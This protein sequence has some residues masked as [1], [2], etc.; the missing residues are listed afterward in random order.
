MEKYYV[1]RFLDESKEVVYVGKT[2]QPIEKRMRIHFSNSGHLGKRQIAKVKCVEFIELENRTEMDIAEL[3]YINKWKPLFNIQSKYDDDCLTYS[4]DDTWEVFD[5]DII[6]EK[7]KEIPSRLRVEVVFTEVDAD[8]VEYLE[9]NDMPR[10]SQIKMALRAQ[11]QRVEEEEL[12]KRIERLLHGVIS[13]ISRNTPTDFKQA[14]LREM[15]EK[16]R[17]AKELEELKGSLKQLIPK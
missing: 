17:L 6:R 1:Y 15:E 8:L 3:Y 7:E 4:R 13:E 12:D 5:L 10:A 14:W 2:K 16:E 9:M 11:I